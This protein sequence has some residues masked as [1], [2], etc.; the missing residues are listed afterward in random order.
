MTQAFG[1]RGEQFPFEFATAG[2]SIADASGDD[3][4]FTIP[5]GWEGYIDLNK[6][7]ALCTTTAVNDG[8]AG[9]VTIK[10]GSTVVATYTVADADAANSIFLF[11]PASGNE[12][13]VTLAAGDT[14]TIASTLGTDA[15]TIAG[16][17]TV[18]LAAYL[19]PLAA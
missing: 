17:F 13:G 2:V 1:G 18:R 19:S 8:T 9:T 10:K 11:T 16:V 5:A 4:V 3:Q 6:C 7:I 15:G 14:F 12:A